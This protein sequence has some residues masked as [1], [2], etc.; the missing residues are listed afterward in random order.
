[1]AGILGWKPTARCA[2]ACR[3]RQEGQ[4]RTR[5]NTFRRLRKWLGE[6]T[7]PQTGADGPIR[8]PEGQEPGVALVYEENTPI[9]LPCWADRQGFKGLN[10]ESRKT[11][12]SEI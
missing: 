10:F 1:M 3:P 9:F 6:L 12:H 2:L 5:D 11:E 7:N 4:Q 8:L